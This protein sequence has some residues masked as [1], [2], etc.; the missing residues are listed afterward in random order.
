VA[1][2]LEVLGPDRI[3]GAISSRFLEERD[4][5]TLRVSEERSLADLTSRRAAIY[6]ITTEIGTLV[7]YEL[8]QAWARC[9]HLAGAQ[10]L[11][12]WLRHDPSRAAG[13][14]LFGAQGE[15]KGWEVGHRGS[16][17]ADLAKKLYDEYGF[18]ILEPPHSEEL[19]FIESR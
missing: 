6:G 17:S 13:V 15:A 14:A 7:P 9:L 16:F 5:W 18:E 19:I 4:I 12:Y 3:G 11:R 1:A 10:G 8:P 2:V